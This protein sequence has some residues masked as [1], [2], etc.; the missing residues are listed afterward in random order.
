MTS[1]KSTFST[2][3]WLT[4]CRPA[5]VAERLEALK[6]RERTQS[7]PLYPFTS[8][9]V[10]GGRRIGEKASQMREKRIEEKK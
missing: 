5:T 1:V 10:G 6:R 9:P 4:P 7:L 2:S 8:R 3:K